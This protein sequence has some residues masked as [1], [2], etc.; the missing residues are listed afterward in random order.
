MRDMIVSNLCGLCMAATVSLAALPLRGEEPSSP[1]AEQEQIAL[2]VKQ[3]GNDDCKTREVATTKLSALGIVTRS[4][5]TAELSNPDLEVRL[6]IKRLLAAVLAEDFRRRLKEFAA[7]TED[8][9]GLDLPGWS[10]FKEAVGGDPEARN[11]FVAMQ[12]DEAE[13]LEGVANFPQLAAEALNRRFIALKTYN[14]NTPPAQNRRYSS[15]GTVATL[16]FVASDPDV[17]LDNKKFDDNLGMWIANLPRQPAFFQ[18]L[19][20]GAGEEIPRRIIKRWLVR[21]ATETNSNVAQMNLDLALQLKLPESLTPAL[22]ILSTE[23]VPPMFRQLAVLSIGLYGNREHIP[24]LEPFLQDTTKCVNFAALK[25][26]GPTDIQTR[27][28]ALAAMIHLAGQDPKDYG[29]E[30]L[31]PSDSTLYVVASVGFKDSDK[32]EAAFKKWRERTPDQTH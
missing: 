1:G 10:K 19:T 28:L 20:D 12:R 30:F 16:L 22:Q 29:Y 9:R 17:K 8:R 21:P 4:A 31:Q 3:L 7:D 13:L 5:L 11:L 27:D 32:R 15:L 23:N 26:P 2:L 24:K 6:R 25:S 14:A 18:S